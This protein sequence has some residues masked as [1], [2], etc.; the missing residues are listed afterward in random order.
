MTRWERFVAELAANL[1]PNDVIG[2][3]LGEPRPWRSATIMEW[4]IRILARS[5]AGKALID[6]AFAPTSADDSIE[7]MLDRWLMGDEL[8]ADHIESYTP[9]S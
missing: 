8:P 7:W 3:T 6:E 4:A 2:K 1:R 9:G 5:D